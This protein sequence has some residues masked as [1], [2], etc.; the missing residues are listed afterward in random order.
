M[1][2]RVGGRTW[3]SYLSVQLE[4]RSQLVVGKE[5]WGRQ[6]TTRG[7]GGVKLGSQKGVI[8]AARNEPKFEGALNSI[9]PRRL[10]DRIRHS[11]RDAPG[12]QRR[13]PCL[14]LSKISMP[15]GLVTN[16]I[17]STNAK[18]AKLSTLTLG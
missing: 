4:I 15:P 2:H 5:I 13:L 9:S 7:G 6:L 18:M 11:I 17:G 10:G 1:A 16:P 14:W 12:V 8:L 3:D